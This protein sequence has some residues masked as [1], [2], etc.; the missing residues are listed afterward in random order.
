MKNNFSAALLCDQGFQVG[1]HSLRIPIRLPWYRALPLSV[2]EIYSL[3]VDDQPIAKSAIALELY[4][5]SYPADELG[6]LINEWWYVLDDATL[7]VQFPAPVPSA[8]HKIELTLNLYPPYIP[9]LNWATACSKL[10]RA[11]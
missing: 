6:E 4:G 1:L 2:V 10:L 3:K 11:G 5:K 8:Q 7:C 9:G